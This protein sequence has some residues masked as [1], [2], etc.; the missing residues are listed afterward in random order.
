MPM[1]PETFSPS[2]Q[3]YDDSMTEFFRI[4]NPE[5]KSDMLPKDDS[6]PVCPTC[7]M[8][9]DFT[10]V[11]PNY[12]VPKRCPDLSHTYDGF[13]IASRKF[14][15]FVESERL[16]GLEF[17]QIPKE[18]DYQTVILTRVIP[19]TEPPELK[20]EEFCETCRRYVSVWGLSHL[21]IRTEPRR[22]YHG[23]Y[24]SNIEMGY[25]LMMFPLL[26]V[27]ADLKDS[28]KKSKLTGLHLESMRVEVATQLA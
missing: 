11:N 14:K 15:N 5:N 18:P 20:R 21:A 17:R 28:I 23:F 3:D 8:V 1:Q 2:I 27:T 19:V 6:G 9:L 16:D 26:F 24:R 13:F 4:S 10:Y 12:R 22:A 7:G 25:R